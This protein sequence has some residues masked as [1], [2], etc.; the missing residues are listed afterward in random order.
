[1]QA[2]DITDAGNETATCELQLLGNYVCSMDSTCFLAR[3]PSHPLMR[4]KRTWNAPIHPATLLCKNLLVGSCFGECMRETSDLR[5][6][7][8]T[9]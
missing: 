3:Y 8:E 5:T 7:D 2:R 1:M 6:W 4:F 9:G